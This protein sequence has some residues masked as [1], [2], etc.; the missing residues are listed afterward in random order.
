MPSPVS[1]P[2]PNDCAG[3]GGVAEASTRRHLPHHASNKRP[4]ASS[5]AIG[6]RRHAPA[7]I[8]TRA[9]QPYARAAAA[10]GASAR[11]V[12]DPASYSIGA[13]S[14]RLRVSREAFARA[15]R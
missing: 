6:H 10:C 2:H 3:A 13:G 1:H 15:G 9:Q 8:T 4:P 14:G 5:S 11:G 12:W 7:G